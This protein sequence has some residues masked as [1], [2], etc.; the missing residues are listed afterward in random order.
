MTVIFTRCSSVGIDHGP[1]DDVRILVRSLLDDRGGLAHL[2]QRKVG[3]A[4]DVDDDAPCTLD[5]GAFQQR[6][7][8]GPLRRFHGPVLAFG[9]ARAHGGEA[10]A[11]HDRLHVG[12][13]EVDQPRHEN[14]VRNA[15]YR[16][17]Q[18]IVCRAERLAEGGGAVDDREQPFVGDR[19]DRVDAV[20]QGL[21]P[22][23]ACVCRF[24]P[25]NLKGLVTTAIVS[26]PSSLARL[27]IT[28]AA[29]CRCRRRGLW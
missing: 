23:S 2:D 10:H 26:A 13:I 6:A 7:R 11:R 18:H 16:L 3:S 25:S 15:L 22:A 19:N 20:A 8:N 1:E 9:D 17:P 14:Q 24:L 21:E 27:A 29:P 5:R 12:E 28:G 4:G